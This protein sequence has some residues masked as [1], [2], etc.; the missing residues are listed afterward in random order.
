MVHVSPC[1]EG[2]GCVQMLQ[3]ALRLLITSSG[4]LD[5]L[6]YDAQLRSHEYLRILQQ[7]LSCDANSAFM[8]P[9]SQW[10]STAKPPAQRL[11]RLTC[12]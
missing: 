11:L 6:Y 1:T 7:H 9:L 3:V 12:R 8:Q 5:P 4:S 10:A 2:D